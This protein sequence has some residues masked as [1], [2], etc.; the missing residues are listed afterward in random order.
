M[1]QAR[2]ALGRLICSAVCRTRRIELAEPGLAQAAAECSALDGSR[3]GQGAIAAT[4]EARSRTQKLP[5]SSRRTMNMRSRCWHRSIARMRAAT[6]RSKSC[7]RARK[8]PKSTDLHIVLADLELAHENTDEARAQLEKVIELQPQELKSS[9]S[10]GALSCACRRNVAAAEKALR[11][12][13]EAVPD[14]VEAK[15]AL[16]DLLASHK[17]YRQGGAGAEGLCRARRRRMRN[18]SWHSRGSM[19]RIAS[20]SWRRQSIARV[21]EREDTKPDGLVARNRLAAMLLQKNETEPATASD[22]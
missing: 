2:A 6:R 7:A 10:A 3:R 5:S 9:L 21:I 12:A 13:V 22:R 16:A 18:C 15:L 8:L 17:Q 11:D 1:M 14:N 4:A 20:R 19:N